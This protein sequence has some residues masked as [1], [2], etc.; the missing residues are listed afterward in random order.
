ML[1]LAF[2]LKY[3]FLKILRSGKG[4]SVWKKVT[5]LDFS[6]FNLASNQKRPRSKHVEIKKTG[7]CAT[8]CGRIILAFKLPMSLET[9]C[10]RAIFLSNSKRYQL[11]DFI[12][13]MNDYHHQH[14]WMDGNGALESR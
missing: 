7:I 8:V 6:P 12:P 9:H 4:R 11:E 5:M 3:P 2:K 14:G 13:T 10:S 1:F